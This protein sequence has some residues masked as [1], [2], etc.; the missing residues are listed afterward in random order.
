VA[1]A[2]RAVEEFEIDGV[3]TTLPLFRDILREPR[4]RAGRYTTAYL[5]DAAADLPSLG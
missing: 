1:R 5:A 2:A 3:A 4:F